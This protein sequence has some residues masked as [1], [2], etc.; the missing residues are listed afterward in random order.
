METALAAAKDEGDLFIIQSE[1]KKGRGELLHR[2][3]KPDKTH[4]E[5]AMKDELFRERCSTV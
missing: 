3:K 2:K 4:Y 5:S 1:R